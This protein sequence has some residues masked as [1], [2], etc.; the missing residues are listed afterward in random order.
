MSGMKRRDFV[1][2]LG[3][4]AVWPLAASAQPAGKVFRRSMFSGWSFTNAE[5]GVRQ[6]GSKKLRGNENG[7]QE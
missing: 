2:L 4:A 6:L 5:A 1:A 3:G 7:W